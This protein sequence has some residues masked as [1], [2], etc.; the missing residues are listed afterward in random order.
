[1][2]ELGPFLL[3]NQEDDM[4]FTKENVAS[5]ELPS[6]R[7]DVIQFDDGLPGFGIRLRAGGK[8]VWIVQ[9]RVHGR[10]RRQTLGDALRI[11]LKAARAAAQKLFAQVALG[12]DPQGDRAEVKA[13][14]TA[15]LGPF[16]DQYL[17]IKQPTVRAS[18]YV[19]DRR[20]LT[21]YWKPLRGTA[22]ES[23]TRRLV[24]VRLNELVKQHGATAAARARQSLSG[25]F[26]WAICEGLV[27]RNPV[28]GTSDP[29]AHT[30]A[31]D[32]VLTADEL[33]VMWSCCGEDDFGRIIRLLMLTGAR[34]DEIGGLRWSE[35]DLDRGR[36]NI[37][38]L[39]TKNHHPLILTLPP[40]AI[41]IL[42]SQPRRAGRRTQPSRRS[43]GG[44]GGYLQS[45]DL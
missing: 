7:S 34:R 45:S 27:E 43:Q 37:P 28:V 31:R 9:Y 30:R 42:S 1:M 23:V 11:D 38:G 25:F 41:S 35:V 44:R 40:T 2:P 29:A 10:Q 26:T 3:P 4:E 36:L 14:A 8:R 17:E 16:A 20:Y 18:T 13:R 32:R 15:R 21:N 24:A 39:R 33:R 6:D 22:I 12:G 5:L 19:A